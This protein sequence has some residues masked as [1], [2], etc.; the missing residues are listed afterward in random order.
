MTVRRVGDEHGQAF[1]YTVLFLVVLLG[2]SALA[3]DVGSWFRAQR[4]L[5]IA[6]D[7]AALA[8]AQELPTSPSAARTKAD[9]YRTLN[10]GG[11]PPATVFD[12]YT[13][14][15]TIAV[16]ATGK[17]PGFF[18]QLFGMVEVDVAARAQA[19]VGPPSELRNVAPIA[20]KN[21]QEKLACSPEP[22][23]N[24][25]TLLNFAESDLTASAFGLIDLSRSASGSVGAAE[26][27]SWIDNGYRG[28]LSVDTW[29]PAVSGQKRGPISDA[30][31]RNAGRPLY[32]PV[33]DVAD[34]ST[35]EFHVIGWA[36]F[37]I[38]AVVE[39]KQDVPECSPNCKVLRGYFVDYL[40]TGFLSGSGGPS[41][42]GVRVV[43]LTS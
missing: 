9:E 6:A 38:E 7:A 26:L 1:V 8:G 3:I 30:L 17:A 4:Q 21:T 32:F 14:D 40:A 11:G 29:F 27:V 2:M 36:A 43:G 37:V 18:S 31:E 20:V 5:Q 16:E 28:S 25:S 13:T 24:E 23:F 12:T 41:Y 39:W 35:R 34:A 10:G 42:Y 15:D 22:C 33:F 19:R